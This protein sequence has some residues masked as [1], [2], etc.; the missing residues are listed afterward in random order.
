MRNFIR[1]AVESLKG[2]MPRQ[3]P[4]W[5]PEEAR[6]G[7]P[8]KK[9]K[10]KEKQDLRPQELTSTAFVQEVLKNSVQRPVSDPVLKVVLC[11]PNAKMPV[12]AT[13]GSGAYDLFLVEDIDVKV[14]QITRTKLGIKVQIPEGFA[15]LI[16]PRS[17]TG[18]R[19]GVDVFGFLDQFRAQF[20][21]GG[22][23]IT[24][25]AYEEVSLP[26]RIGY[27]NSD[28]RDELNLALT[29][30]C[31]F[32]SEK[33]ILKYKVGD[34][35]AQLVIMPVAMLPLVQAQE[36]DPSHRGEGGIGSTGR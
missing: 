8:T 17:S 20:I 29:R 21:P 9:A 3:E 23:K 13:P 6:K 36:L 19:D 14:W 4:I 28:Y 16:F 2:M 15:G 35:V 26:N 33:E 12:Q 7:P 30:T 34:R 32:V 22:G 24:E 27:I 18:F 11:H 25:D 5:L 31:G 10:K 1:Q